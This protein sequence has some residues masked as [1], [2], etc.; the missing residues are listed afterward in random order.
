MNEAHLAFGP[1]P[2]AAGARPDAFGID[3][4][5]ESA[6]LAGLADPPEEAD[7]PALGTNPDPA[8][9]PGGTVGARTAALDAGASAAAP[10][11]PTD[12][13]DPD[14][15]K[16]ARVGLPGIER[17][18]PPPERPPNPASVPLL[19]LEEA[20]DGAY[21]AH[22]SSLPEDRNTA[23]EPAAFDNDAHLRLAEAAEARA[24]GA[25]ASAGLFPGT[26]S[27]ARFEDRP[28]GGAAELGSGSTDDPDAGPG[29]DASDFEALLQGLSDAPSF[30]PSDTPSFREADPGTPSTSSPEPEVGSEPM[31][32]TGNGADGEPVHDYSALAKWSPPAFSPDPALEQTLREELSAS[33][34]ISASHDDSAAP[35]LEIG[36]SP[37]AV[38]EPTPDLESRAVP[39]FPSF[40]PGLDSPS[41]SEDGAPSETVGEPTVLAFA[42]DPESESALREGLSEHP[43]PQV[44]PGGLRSAIATLGA[45]QS[46]PVLFVDLDET[47]YPAGAIHELAAV[48]E[49]GTVVIAFGSDGTARFS[50]EVLL[51]GVSDYLVKPITAAAVR[52]AAAR[53]AASARAEAAEDRGGGWSIGFAGTGG[54]GATTLAAAA[55]LLA[56]E[57]GRYVSVLDLN[58]TFPTL[59]FLLDVEPAPGLVELLSTVARASLHPDVVDGMRAE[60]SDRITVY[61]YPW[62]AIPPPCP[63]VWAIC[64]LIVELQR[65]SHLVIV[66]GLDDPATRISLL[67]TVDARVVVV[68]PTVTGAACAARMLDRFGPMFDPDWPLLLVQN[69]TRP[70]KPKAGA[71][72]LRDAGVEASPEVVVPFEPALPAHADRGWPQ[73]RLPRSLRK[74]FAALADRILA[75]PA[76][77]PALV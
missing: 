47:P 45:G 52:E 29:P 32:R 61:G 42:T 11:P 59:S 37:E 77:V 39:S 60:R 69:H 46:S 17:P 70:L 65:R 1:S 12:Q 20:S 34:P 51:A 27:E 4:D 62:N 18:E 13:S 33:Q 56:A 6:L 19:D 8:E 72:I 5:L 54:S 38:P 7:G 57:R 3:D 21:P 73:G 71:R 9:P 36:P 75:A 63:P 31:S 68:E 10:V 14:G 28:G 58:R 2:P 55:A 25:D 43:N 66:D 49:I 44:W 22:P 15:E 41:L 35:D 23:G 26:D 67:A 74:S 40:D 16:E 64:E 24:N 48:C 30:S 76:A 53:A 50:R